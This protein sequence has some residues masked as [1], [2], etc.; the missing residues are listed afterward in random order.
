MVIYTEKRWT[1]IRVSYVHHREYYMYVLYTAHQN[2]PH[3]GHNQLAKTSSWLC[4]FSVFVAWCI[5]F[6]SI[7]SSESTWLRREKKSM[8]DHFL[9]RSLYWLA[10]DIRMDFP[11]DLYSF[12]RKSVRISFDFV[13]KNVS[14]CDLGLNIVVDAASLT[15][16]RLSLSRHTFH[17]PPS[18]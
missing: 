15:L 13:V 5:A 6:A 1:Q 3:N 11:L 18:E 8:R 9:F 7:D 16:C 12:K 10:F 4:Q 14:Y 17:I 2:L